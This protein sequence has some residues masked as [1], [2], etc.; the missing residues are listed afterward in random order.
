MVEKK[1]KRIAGSS[2]MLALKEG[3]WPGNKG[4][5]RLEKGQGGDEVGLIRKALDLEYKTSGSHGKIL[6]Q[7][8]EC[9]VLSW[10]DMPATFEEDW[11]SHSPA[12]KK[13]NCDVLLLLPQFSH[14]IGLPWWLSGNESAC[15][16]RRHRFDPRSGKIPHA[17]EQLSPFT[18]TIEPVL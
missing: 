2:L 4:C 15:Q 3:C 18:T 6:S 8:H 14:H 17:A 1:Q 5:S 9:T 13:Q 7:T 16:C 10:M 11:L 12:P